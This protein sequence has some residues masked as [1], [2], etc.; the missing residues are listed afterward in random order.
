MVLRRLILIKQPFEKT[1]TLPEVNSMC[2]IIDS[3]IPLSPPASTS[4]SCPVCF[5]YEMLWA[6]RLRLQS[7]LETRRPECQR[8]IVTQPS[9]EVGGAACAL[10]SA[11]RQC[12]CPPAA[13]VCR[14]RLGSEDAK[15]EAAGPGAP[16]AP[17]GAAPSLN[18]NRE[19]P[20]RSSGRRVQGVYTV[21]LNTTALCKLA[22]S[23]SCR[24]DREWNTESEETLDE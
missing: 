18:C 22:L 14:R 23:P 21:F 4:T 6:P 16:R 8:Q 13:P 12:S 5:S 20:P 3:F 17:S 10:R 11:I 2:P 1:E 9:T 7:N 24:F 19:G 15:A